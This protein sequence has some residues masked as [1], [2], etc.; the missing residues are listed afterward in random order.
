MTENNQKAPKIGDKAADGWIYAGISPDTGKPM[1][2][3][4]EDAGVMSLKDG[5]KAAKALQ[6][7]G[8]AEARVPS[9]EELKQLFNNRA[10]IGG[11]QKKAPGA[12][13]STYTYRSTSKSKRFQMKDFVDTLVFSENCPGEHSTH[14]K[15]GDG[16][17]D[18]QGKYAK[19]NV[20]LVRS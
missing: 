9:I 16:H 5:F 8:K 12:A 20:R 10:A 18:F 11:F 14:V 6:Q 3:A 17:V 19:Y 7:Q 2:A 13:Q 4:P 15:G 1:Y